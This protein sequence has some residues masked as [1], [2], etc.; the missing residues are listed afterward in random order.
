[1]TAW[2][3]PAEILQDLAVQTACL[4]MYSS[5]EAGILDNV[6]NRYVDPP[7]WYTPPMMNT[8]FVEM[9]GEMTRINTFYGICSELCSV[10][11]G[12]Y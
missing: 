4:G 5:A 11:L 8:R 6:T 1:M 10:R 7:D 12:Q 9:S 2:N 3:S